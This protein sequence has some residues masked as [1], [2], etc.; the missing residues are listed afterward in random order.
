MPFSLN[1]GWRLAVGECKTHKQFADQLH[2]YSAD[3]P[4]LPPAP[5]CRQRAVHLQPT[6][7]MWE[8]ACFAFVLRTYVRKLVVEV[9]LSLGRSATIYSR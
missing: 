8:P 7:V 1:V 3:L 4:L 5:Q 6:G 9:H 2:R